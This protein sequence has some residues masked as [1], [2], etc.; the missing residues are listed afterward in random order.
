[1]ER[2]TEGQRLKLAAATLLAVITTSGQPLI[3]PGDYTYDSLQG[4]PV[5]EKYEVEDQFFYTREDFFRNNIYSLPTSI[6]LRDS[7]DGLV[8]IAYGP[9]WRTEAITILLDSDYDACVP[10][11]EEAVSIYR[12]FFNEFQSGQVV[13]RD[14]MT[15]L[16]DRAQDCSSFN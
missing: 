3:D 5:D 16:K 11:S 6:H 4:V 8:Y 10:A 12:Q 2:D 7:A 9:G 14:L 1:M 15:E 13:N